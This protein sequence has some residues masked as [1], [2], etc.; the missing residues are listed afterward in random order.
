[1]KAPVQWA[2]AAAALA[3]AAAQGFALRAERRAAAPPVPA[4]SS[5][6]GTAAPLVAFA[7]VALGGFRGV[8]AD[9]LWFRA[10]RLQDERRFVEL[11]QL[12]DWITALDPANEEAWVFH[13]WN[14]AYNVS[15]L[16]PRPEDRWR[17]VE[18][19]ISLLRDRGIPLNPRS[20]ELRRQLGWFF[21]HKI[22]MGTDEASPHYRSEWA[23]EAAA[24]L[25]PGGAAPPAGSIVAAE[26]AGTLKMDAAAMAAL[27]ARFGAIDWRVPAAS[28]LYWAST[29][30][31]NGAPE[32][33]ELPCRRMVYQSLLAMA[34]GAGRLLGN[35][36]EEGW[37]F[38][39]APNPA[40]LD[41]ALAFLEETMRTSPFSGLRHAY[42]GALREGTLLR[43]Y[44]GRDADARALHDR[45]RAF[46]ASVGVADGV[47]AYE[48]LPS[49]PDD[50]SARLLERAGF[51]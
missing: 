1:M 17:W 32:K 11:V 12:A 50:W 34:F 38:D 7:S 13:A 48:D 24:Y 37:T 25:G 42:V 22:G 29:A 33:D 23:R 21:Q 36:L 40:L 43:A 9:A 49:A 44:E 5:A 39:A 16:L 10:D 8:L 47:P 27:E 51:R 20:A 26:L 46:F 2:A 3:A 31:E 15:Y 4:L 41:P 18:G 6:G 19:G 35:P 45:L 28:S 14:M 30:L